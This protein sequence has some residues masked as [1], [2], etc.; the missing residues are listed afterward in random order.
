MSLI[1]SVGLI[2]GNLDE[3]TSIVLPVEVLK[4]RS[5]IGLQMWVNSTLNPTT[6]NWSS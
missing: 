1:A 3:S 2:S 6:D 4:S 5:R